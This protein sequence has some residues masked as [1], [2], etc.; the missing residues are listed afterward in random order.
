V[1]EPSEIAGLIS[2]MAS[3]DAGYMTGASVTIDGGYT[4]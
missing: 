4:L 2:Y 3:A 1:A